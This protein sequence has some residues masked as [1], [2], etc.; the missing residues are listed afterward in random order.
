MQTFSGLAAGIFFTFFIFGFFLNTAARSE[1][2]QLPRKLYW[3]Y[4]FVLNCFFVHKVQ[5]ALSFHIGGEYVMQIFSRR[6]DFS[7]FLS[8]HS[9]VFSAACVPSRDFRSVGLRLLSLS[10]LTQARCVQLAQ[11]QS[12]LLHHKQSLADFSLP[13][14]SCK[15]SLCS[16]Y[17]SG[18]SLHPKFCVAWGFRWNWG[19]SRGLNRD[20]RDCQCGPLVPCSSLSISHSRNLCLFSTQKHLSIPNFPALLL[21]R[22]NYYSAA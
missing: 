7:G 6:R 9:S 14:L 12:A 16:F 19:V 17:S 10:L 5:N 3:V 4:I 2:K 15:C 21:F 11:P 8:S 18:K 1:E 22:E 20:H 13:L